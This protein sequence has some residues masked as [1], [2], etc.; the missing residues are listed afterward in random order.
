MKQQLFSEKDESHGGHAD[1]QPSLNLT[2]M[3]GTMARLPLDDAYP[4][5]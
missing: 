3:T 2:H 5:P 4:E 1:G